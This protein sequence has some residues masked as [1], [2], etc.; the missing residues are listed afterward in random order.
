MERLT[1]ADPVDLRKAMDAAGVYVK[2]GILFVPIPVM[3]KTDFAVLVDQAHDRLSKL[4]D[5]TEVEP[6]VKKCARDRC[7]EPSV[8][9][10][11][12]HQGLCR[13]HAEE[14]RQRQIAS[15]S[16]L[17]CAECGNG[18]GLHE[19]YCRRCREQIEQEQR[20]RDE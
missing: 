15:M 18:S 14:R 9:L 8:Q 5:R 17:K 20:E 11:R 7:T 13:V 3:D 10:H 16:H 12:K 1:R 4:I 2:A 6:K 19:I